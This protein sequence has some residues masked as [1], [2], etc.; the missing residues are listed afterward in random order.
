[1]ETAVELSGVGF[2]YGE[3]DIEDPD[4]TTRVFSDVS[5]KLPAGMLSIV[6]RN[7]I[8]KSTLLLLA[9]ARLF[10]QQGSVTILGT[11]TRKFFQAQTDPQ[12]EQDRN[13]F[14]SFVYQNMEFETTESVGD[15]MRFAYENGFHE[16]P[17]EEFLA[18]IRSEL[19]MDPFL[20]K[21]TGDLSKG[22]LQRAIIAFSLLYG[23]RIIMLDEPVFALEEPQ[24]DRVFRFLLELS[25]ELSLPI[26]YSVHN[27]DLSQKYA[28]YVLLFTE[29]GRFTIG[30][31]E[32]IFTREHLEEAYLAPMD[33]LY[34]RDQLYREM[35]L[36]NG[37]ENDD[38]DA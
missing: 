37:R 2:F 35:L 17:A 32:Q 1:M 28:D 15:L 38:H 29:T 6:G 19:E 3:H 36:H 33:T 16:N 23:S 10:P 11:D 24:K 5:V 22:Q 8:G 20:A 18:R 4:E 25:R 13:R 30:P 27:L 34:R 26:F 12:I 21:R 7:G 9:G 14:V 31:S